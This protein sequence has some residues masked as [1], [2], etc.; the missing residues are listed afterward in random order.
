MA[1]TILSSLLGTLK[2]TFRVNKATLDA[3]G[4]TAARSFTLPDVA[5]QVM[6][7]SGTTKVTVGT[8]A[9]S[10]PAVGELW[11]DTN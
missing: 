9:P 3:S 10:T 2:S 4:L 11:I 6:L 8:S 5:G 7:G 1:S